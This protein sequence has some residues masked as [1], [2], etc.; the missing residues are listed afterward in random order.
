MPFCSALVSGRLRAKSKHISSS[1][2]LPGTKVAD[3]LLAGLVRGGELVIVAVDHLLLQ[4]H[5]VLFLDLRRGLLGRLRRRH[6]DRCAHAALHSLIESAKVPGLLPDRGHL[7][8]VLGVLEG[9]VG[10]LVLGQH[11][12]QHRTLEQR[13]VAERGSREDHAFGAVELDRVHQQLALVFFFLIVLGRLL[14]GAVQER[15]G[16]FL[17]RVAGDR[18]FVQQPAVHQSEVI[19][20]DITAGHL[21]RL[22]QP[23]RRLLAERAGEHDAGV[24][25]LRALFQVHGGDV[26][27]DQLRV[28]FG[29][30]DHSRAHHQIDLGGRRLPGFLG[31]IGVE[32]LH[33]AAVLVVDRDRRAQRVVGDR[34]AGKLA[35]VVAQH[36]HLVDV[37]FAADRILVVLRH[38]DVAHVL[39]L[40]QDLPHARQVADHVANRRK[41]HAVQAVQP[42]GEAQFEGRARDAADVALVVGV[43]LNHF[44]L[45]AAAEDAHRQHARGM[46]DFAR[47]VD[48]HVADRLAPGRGRLPL[49][50]HVEVQVL[51]QP[52]AALHDL[53]D[54]HNV[55]PSMWRRD[56]PPP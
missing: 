25:A 30:Q 53:L 10:H 35:E 27:A 48:R 20:Y 1:L 17:Q 6:L 28:F 44:E 2:R 37:E 46:D 33:R 42:P 15:L 29:G 23:Q 51:E 22:D 41:Q 52:L 39:V 50:D 3:D 54:C 7:A 19:I 5:R 13:R 21:D 11:V 16:Q 14:V 18:H 45:I 38:V 32:V 36:L 26:I 40:E 31:A 43:A 34:L 47:H 24:V 49:L 56:S 8:G 9:G 4:P 12:L 55:D